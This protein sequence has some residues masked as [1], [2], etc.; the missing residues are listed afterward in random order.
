MDK[1]IKRLLL[2][3]CIV[4]FLLCLYDISFAYEGAFENTYCPHNNCSH[5]M[6]IIDSFQIQFSVGQCQKCS[7]EY[8]NRVVHCKSNFTDHYYLNGE[9]ISQDKVDLLAEQSSLQKQ[10]N[11]QERNQNFYI[12]RNKVSAI[13]FLSAW[14]IL[15]FGFVSGIIGIAKGTKKKIVVF[16][17]KKDM[18]FA[19]IC[20]GAILPSLILG[21][22][23]FPLWLITIVCFIVSIIY[24]IKKSCQFGSTGWD[25]WFIFT[26]RSL[27]GIMSSPILWNLI[28]GQTER[29]RSSGGSELLHTAFWAGMAML[30]YKWLMKFVK[31]EQIGNV[32]VVN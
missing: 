13:L 17:T 3:A 2:E 15:I 22:F 20:V 14:V 26:A 19:T 18:L 31:E 4:L 25:K 7:K 32:E 27:L 1:R 9:I 24:N 30:Y 10:K 5:A 16:T 8:P 28:G 6:N 23:C 21:I 11:Q 12:A 29:Q